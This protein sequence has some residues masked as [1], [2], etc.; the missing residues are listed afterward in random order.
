MNDSCRNLFPRKPIQR[1]TYLLF[2]C[3]FLFVQKYG[4]Q[5]SKQVGLKGPQTATGEIGKQLTSD[6]IE[7]LFSDEQ[8]Q[9]LY[10][11]Y[12]ASTELPKSEINDEK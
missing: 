1:V 9:Q 11:L 8:L 4:I 10:D 7:T 3:L 5:I 12:K 2:T 6:D